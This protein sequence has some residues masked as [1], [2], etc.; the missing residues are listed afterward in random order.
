MR[1]NIEVLCRNK[2]V[3]YELL[4]TRKQIYEVGLVNRKK[5]QNIKKKNKKV[6]VLSMTQTNK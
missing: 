6:F 2:T 4:I 1:V 3:L 5:K